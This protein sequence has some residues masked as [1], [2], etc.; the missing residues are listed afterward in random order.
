MFE[1]IFSKAEKQSEKQKQKIKIIAD[2][3]EKNSMVIA[4]LTALGAEIE[5]KKLE[6]GDYIV[7][8]IIIER[9]TMSDFVSSMLN[10][11]LRVQLDNLKRNENPLLIIENFDIEQSG[12]NPNCIRGFIMSIILNYKIPIIFTQ[13][14]K[15][16]AEY[17]VL[18]AKKQERGTETLRIKKKYSNKKEVLRYILEGFPGIGPATAK[19]L[20][21][22]FKN[23]KGIINAD[24]NELKGILGKK[25]GLFR[26]IINKIY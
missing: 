8:S 14:S 7:S 26:E 2:V 23:I 25:T 1:N 6:V 17:L 4:E 11:R 13:D 10:K 21:K 9:K 16:T 19:K 18:L 12:V 15:D 22:K 5:Q 3:H 24:E 20:L